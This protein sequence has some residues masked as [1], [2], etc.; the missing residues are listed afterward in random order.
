MKRTPRGE[1]HVLLNLLDQVGGA[2]AALDN[3]LPALVFTLVFVATGRSLRLAVWSA[4]AV[5]GVLLVLRL[6]RREPVRNAVSGFLAIAVAA[7]I[8]SATGRA[9]DY[10]LVSIVRNAALAVGYAV[11]NL[12]RYPLIGLVVGL[13]RGNVTG[14]RSDPGQL[15][16]YTRATWIWVGLFVL[17]L[18]VRTPL[19]LSSDVTWL[20]VTEVVMGWPLFA[21]T[22]LA[23]YLYLRRSL[24]AD[25]WAQA[26]ASILAR[27]S[28]PVD[29]G[30]PTDEDVP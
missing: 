6:A 28:R 4:L 3:A 25:H 1:R 27:G 24:H 5:G 22:I 16:A 20:G 15:R 17:R 11:S 9:A 7:A 19:L 23:T 21:A 26:Q 18:G 14:F 29:P 12:V 30:E 10:F 2:G 8:A 13:A